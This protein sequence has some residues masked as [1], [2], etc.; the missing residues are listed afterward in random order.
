MIPLKR[1]P[2]LFGFIAT[3]I[4]GACAEAGPPLPNFDLPVVTSVIPVQPTDIIP[5]PANPNIPNPVFSFLYGRTL[6]AGDLLGT[7]IP[8]ILLAP[9][10]FNWLPELP[11]RIL[12]NDGTGHYSDQAPN[13][14]AGS[15]P[16]TGLVGNIFIADFDHSG[17]PG[18]FMV[19]GGLLDAPPGGSPGHRNG[20][21]LW[22]G[23]GHLHDMSATLPTG[24]GFFS[25]SVVDLYGKG[26]Q[27]I[28]LSE[29]NGPSNRGGYLVLINDGRGNF[30]STTSGL[31]QEIAAPLGQTSGI[32]WQNPG[33]NAACDLD[34]DGLVDIVTG[35]YGGDPETGIPSIRF[36]KQD[37]NLNFTEQRS[38]RL[39]IPT[40]L[41]NIGFLGGTR[42]P[43]GQY[44]GVGRISCG[45]LFGSGRN[46]LVISWEQ[47]NP[48]N[49]EIL[50]ND[51][52]FVFTDVTVSALGAY[53]SSVL[54]GDFT[55]I[56]VNGDGLL[57]LVLNPNGTQ[58]QPDGSLGFIDL[59][60]GN[61]TFSPMVI[62]SGGAP[63][64]AAGLAAAISGLCPFPNCSFFPLITNMTAAGNRDIVLLD[65][66]TSSPAGLP[67]QVTQVNVYGLLNA[68]PGPSIP[69][70]SAVL[71][72]SRAVQVGTRA[73]I[74]GTMLDDGGVPL[75][76]CR[77]TLP[78]NY[79]AGLSVAFQQTNPA[80][81]A[82]V[83]VPYGPAAVTGASP[84]TFLLTF[85]ASQALSLT[86]QPLSF[87]CD[88][89]PAASRTPGVNTVD[90]LFSN[91]PVADVIALAATE[92]N[93]GIVDVPFSS[94]ASGAFAVASI[95]VGTS[96]TLNV[97][98][99]TG[100][101]PLPLSATVC[102][103]NSAAICV[104]PTVPVPSFPLSFAPN[105]SPTF[106]VFV[107]AAGAI[108]FAPATARVFL[109]FVDGDGVE[110]GSTSVAVRTQ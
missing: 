54:V 24:L 43:N 26:N 28:V 51:G 5:N 20:L 72:G 62:Q 82:L 4:A 77:V 39:T 101:T 22:G 103:T 58:A 74:F 75:A 57:D 50:R 53:A 105:A 63:L 3:I 55:L 92:S 34:G 80:T 100:G 91:T 38:A 64:G 104:S 46:D 35:S 21:Y 79:P 7:G 73:T 16:T 41:S 52:D 81:N 13:L 93:N 10:H 84:G 23:D 12:V 15:V 56:D 47:A 95:N 102:E 40:A 70:V 19:D 65:G 108:P 6:A 59:N 87:G 106:S 67:A 17:R 42:G 90:L 25:S 110:H 68:A 60:N 78:P 88:G 98:T 14:F 27:D 32:D 71:P 2:A 96:G 31:P 45:N 33:A 107:T 66:V 18:V 11:V 99:D 49:I 94:G 69:V 86:A 61:G 109:R 97:T 89:V 1:S 48:N 29:L 9:S 83:G 76:N 30:T 8:V 37:A 44:L 36:F 85:Q